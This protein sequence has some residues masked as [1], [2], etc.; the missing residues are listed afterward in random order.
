MVGAV[1]R[2]PRMQRQA[3]DALQ[4]GKLLVRK[5][6]TGKRVTAA[7]RG[8]DGRR[9]PDGR[10]RG[11]DCRLRWPQS[12]DFSGKSRFA[13]P[14]A[15]HRPT[16]V[17]DFEVVPRPTH[18]GASTGSMATRSL[19]RVSSCS[20]PQDA[21]FSILPRSFRE[22][23]RALRVPRACLELTIRSE[24]LNPDSYTTVSST[25]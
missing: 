14:R 1:R 9:L 15:R 4:H 2:D 8:G 3:P 10:R 6:N 7:S 20:G 13:S 5:V 24:Y 25:P 18:S 16:R 21:D 12:R 23:S 19:V 11:E 17:P 22:F